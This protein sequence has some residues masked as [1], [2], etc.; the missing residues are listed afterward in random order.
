MWPS[1]SRIPFCILAADPIRADPSREFLRILTCFLL[2]GSAV[3]RQQTSCTSSE[4]PNPT[5]RTRQDPVGR[6]SLLAR[7]RR[8]ASQSCAFELRRDSCA[9]P[10]PL[11]EP[12]RV[13]TPP[14]DR[15]VSPC[16]I[17]TCMRTRAH[18]L[19]DRRTR[20][21]SSP[22]RRGCGQG[23][24][25]PTPPAANSQTHGRRASVP[26]TVPRSKSHPRHSSN[27]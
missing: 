7:S 12:E 9:L 27:L 20:A 6:N 10:P 8:P 3:K 2:L 24:V 17:D 15:K 16:T 21:S 25:T 13:R 19:S 1:F 22:L 5:D 23:H 14:E 11:R 4:Q 26:R 18:S